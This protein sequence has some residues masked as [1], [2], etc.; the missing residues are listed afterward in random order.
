MCGIFGYISN[1][2]FL[3]DNEINLSRKKTKELSHRGPDHYGEWYSNNIFMGIQRLSI[4]DLSEN[5]NQPFIFNDKALIFNGEIYNHIQYK[6]VLEKRGYKFKSNCDTEVFF[7]FILEF[8]LDNIERLNGMFSFIFYDGLNLHFGNDIFSEKTLFYFKDS[9]RLIISS[10]LNNLKNFSQKSNNQELIFSYLTFGHLI[11]DKTFYKN[12]Y[13]LKPGQILTVN[14][15]LDLK[16]FKFFDPKK[17]YLNS[18][19]SIKNENLSPNAFFQDIDKSLNLRFQ[20]DRSMG[21]LFS[22]GLD[23]SIVADRYIANKNDT[24]SFAIYTNDKKKF[25][26]NNLILN[27]IKSVSFLEDVDFDR[28][29]KSILELFGQPMD[30]FTSL[31][32]KNLCKKL[33]EK[34]IYC[35]LS[36][37]GGDELFFGYNKFFDYQEFKFKLKKFFKIG[38]SNFNLSLLLKSNEIF[39][40]IKNND[41]IDWMDD[42]FKFN[43][44]YTLIENIF[45][46]DLEYF[47]PNSRCLTS[48]VSSMKHGVEL[49]SSF[50]DIELLKKILS[51]D[52]NLISKYGKKKI[53]IDFHQN[54]INNFNN[55]LK[56][57]F[58]LRPEKIDNSQEDNLAYLKTYFKNI[59]RKSL[60][61][62]LLERSDMLNTF[63]N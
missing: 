48:D 43:Q 44:N 13:K 45:F 26:E 6:K 12:I 49:R 9:N 19:N 31:A 15:D 33:S 56:Y 32:I 40:F 4:N 23:S 22:G 18:K 24:I 21:L 28:N 57:S 63:F 53:L 30:S 59:N 10:E 35:A 58:S 29:N 11:E 39:D 50:L 52:L 2:N 38:V 34:N 20:S 42:N 5:G 46:N 25:F 37:L 41:F 54:K 60:K 61:I 55:Y 27:K 47:L 62:S 14:K 51:Y 1:K 3:S 7:Y 16:S 8:G 17:F 36:G